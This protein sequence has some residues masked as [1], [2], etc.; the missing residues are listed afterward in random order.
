[1]TVLAPTPIMA[2]KAAPRFMNGLATAMPLIPMS[3]TPCPTNMLSTILY[4]DDATMAM[5]AGMAYPA[6]S[7][8]MGCSPNSVGTYC[9]VFWLILSV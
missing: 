8:P 1:M 6:R 5:M 3:P 7:F 4:T 2:P 9:L